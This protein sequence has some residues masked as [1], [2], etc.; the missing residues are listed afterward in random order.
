MGTNLAPFLA[1]L[2]FAMLQMEVKNKSAHDKNLKCYDNNGKQKKVQY[3]MTQFNL[4][5]DTIKIDQ[6]SFG[7]LC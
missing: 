1:N 6:W 2:C 3:W 5:R 7:T 4:L